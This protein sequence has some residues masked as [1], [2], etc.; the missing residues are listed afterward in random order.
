MKVAFTTPLK[1]LDLSMKH[2]DY[3]F[4]V[5]PTLVEGL[6]DEIDTSLPIYLDNG[7]YEFGSS[8]PIDEFLTVI[9]IV[10]PAVVIVPDR[11][12]HME[13]TLRLTTRFFDMV[14]KSWFSRFKFMIVPQGRTMDQWRHCF[15][16]MLRKFR[17]MFHLVGIPK[18][19]Y[20]ARVNA[21]RFVWGR[22]RK[23]SH[24]LGCPNPS[25]IPQIL[26]ANAP[27]ESID[28]TWPARHS[29]GKLD[30]VLDLVNDELDPEAFD[31]S[32]ALF[33]EKSGLSLI[34]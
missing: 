15:L 17:G 9:E 18:Y 11:P 12:Q 5:A 30:E 25:E 24:L 19:L 7:A 16:V 10:N 4:L 13:E 2:S 27:V 23:F 31:K 26:N 1:N 34:Q 3:L 6:V 28:T 29:L 32:C 8:M 22:S 21:V 14:P 33:L 20:P